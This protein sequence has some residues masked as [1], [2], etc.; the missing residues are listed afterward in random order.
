VRPPYS[1]FTHIDRN[2]GR[3]PRIFQWSIGLQREITHDLVVEAAYVGNRGAWWLSPVLD[4][5]NA[6]TP[7]IL[8]TNGLDINSAADRAILRAPINSA[9]AGRF[10][11]KIPYAGFPG[12]ASVAQALRPYPQFNSGLAPLWAPE[13]R[14]W[15][16]SLQAK[17]TQRVNHGLEAQFAF[18]WAKELQSGTE[19]GT[20][21]DVF[22][23]AT[24]KT[25]SGFSR[26]LVSVLSINYRVPRPAGN[27]YVSQ[28][29][30]DWALG[31]TLNYSSGVPILAPSST[32]NLTTLLFRGTFYN[33]V[34]DQPLFLK[35][36]NCHCIDPTKDL[37]L[38]PA[39]WTNPS[40][41]QWSVSAPYYSDYR[42]E[43]RP[44]E[45]MSV[46]RVFQIGPEGKGAKLTVRMNFTNIFNRTQLS[47]P[48]ATTPSAAT[49][50]SSAGLLTGGF[51]FVNYQGGSTFLPSR[52]GTLEMRLQF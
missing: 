42:Y 44:S 8:S 31:T 2:S 51:G 17:V 47:N 25:I 13:G 32:N 15:Y 6:L 19:A 37:V 48:A 30:R 4:N 38:N 22:N 40:D 12:T 27:R 43:R 5:N 16:D 34:P 52:Q 14:T 18:T 33:R 1:P 9:G 41:G 10:Q 23:R 3:P 35:D 29:L 36:L 28:V 45:S 21:N 50:K 26:P 7:Q 39:A 49:I 20:V 24:T 11:N 46:G